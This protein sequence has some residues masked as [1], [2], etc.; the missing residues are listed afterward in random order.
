[1]GQIQTAKQKVAN[2][3]AL[4][5]GDAVRNQ[6]AMVAPR[7]LTPDRIIRIAMTSIQRTPKLLDCTPESLLGSLLTCTQLG[8]EPD[9]A[10]GRAYLVPYKTTCTLIVGYRGLM[11]LARRSGDIKSLEARIVHENDKFEFEYGSA[12]GVRHVPKLADRGKPI[13]AYAVAVL[14]DGGIQYEVMSADE[15]NAIR[16]RSKAANDGPWKTDWSEMARKTVMRRLCKYLPSSP[17]LSQAVT[18]GDEAE[19]GI[20]QSVAFVDIE[21]AK[22]EPKQLDD[23]VPGGPEHEPKPKPNKLGET[24]FGKIQAAAKGLEPTKR[25]EVLAQHGLGPKSPVG[26][27]KDM[28][29]KQQDALL[30]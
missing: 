2:V 20:P 30:I 15:I 6:I 23:F 5:T 26:A 12:A 11:E 28:D 9:G 18:L 1:M 4:L 16:D 24:T 8:L 17:E 19:A 25:A 13:A 10:A 22:S 29:S 7:H 21:P 3:R 14:K 27:I